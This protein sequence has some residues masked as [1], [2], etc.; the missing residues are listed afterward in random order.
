MMSAGTLPRALPLLFNSGKP[1]DEPARVARA[2]SYNLAGIAGAKRNELFEHLAAM[3]ERIELVKRR[4]S[5]RKH[6][7]V[8]RLGHRNRRIERVFHML[9]AN[10]L[11]ARIGE[12]IEE[13]LAR[14]AKA[15][16]GLAFRIARFNKLVK[17]GSLVIAAEQENGGVGSKRRKR[18]Q[19]SVHVGRLGIVHELH[20]ADFAA[21]LQ[22]MFERLKGHE[23]FA[24]LG[25]GLGNSRE[26]F[27][28]LPEAETDFIFSIIGE[29]LG[30]VGALFVIA[31]FVAVLVGGLLIAKRASDDFGTM[32]AGGLT[33][34]LVGQAFLNMACATGLFPTT[35]KPLPFISSGGSSVVASLLMVGII[36][37]VS[38]VAGEEALTP[39][40]AS[41]ERRRANLSYIRV[42]DEPPARSRF[43]SVESEPIAEHPARSRRSHGDPF[44]GVMAPRGGASRSASRGSSRPEGNASMGSRA[45]RR[46]DSGMERGANRRG[47]GRNS[48]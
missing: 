22:A 34:M 9:G 16:H 30:F 44:G 33:C 37:S 3:L 15:H 11:H 29:E 38:R 35:G 42:E 1:A 28:Y 21:R 24:H 8:A 26:K 14:R 25:V 4:A 41:A 31:L 43:S 12:R 13:A 40:R 10:M 17:V 7:L 45:S 19:R 36:M 20:A 2:T 32:I 6:D 39:H 27:L 48:R 23:A 5:G 18:L 46:H 47:S